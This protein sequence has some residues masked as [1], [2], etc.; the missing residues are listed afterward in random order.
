MGDY[1]GL[2]PGAYSRFSVNEDFEGVGKAMN[3][4]LE[5]EGRM[6]RVGLRQVLSPQQWTKVII[7]LLLL[8]FFFIYLFI[9]FFFQFFVSNL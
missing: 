5:G 4:A 9:F 1:I 7:L 2:G 8:L 6:K 3:G